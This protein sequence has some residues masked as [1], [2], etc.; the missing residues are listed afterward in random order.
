MILTM[1]QGESFEVSLARLEEQNKNLVIQLA[2]ITKALTDFENRL[3][4]LEKWCAWTLGSCA[5][6]AFI[7]PFVVKALFPTKT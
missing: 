7:G 3:R 5:V 1:S 6:L 4:V 2:A